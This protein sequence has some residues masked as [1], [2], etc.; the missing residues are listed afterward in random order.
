[1]PLYPLSLLFFVK[2]TDS[3]MSEWHSDA[4][5]EESLDKGKLKT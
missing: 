4:T 2:M 1:M 3:M 5:E